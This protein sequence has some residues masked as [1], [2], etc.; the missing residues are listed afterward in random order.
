MDF[1]QKTRTLAT[2]PG[3]YLYKNA[4]GGVIHVDKAANLRGRVGSDFRESSPDGA[5]IGALIRET[6]DLKC[7]VVANAQG[8]RRGVSHTLSEMQSYANEEES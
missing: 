4:E 6:A 7:I 5:E 8:R 3:V 1:S 2:E